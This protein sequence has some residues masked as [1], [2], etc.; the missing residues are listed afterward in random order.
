MAVRTI[1]PSPSRSNTPPTSGH[2]PSRSPSPKFRAL[3]SNGVLPGSSNALLGPYIAVTTARTIYQTKHSGDREIKID[4]GLRIIEVPF[5]VVGG[6]GSSITTAFT[7]GKLLDLFTI[8]AQV[9]TTATKV[10]VIAGFIICG[11]EAIYESIGLKRAIVFLCKIHGI[12]TPRHFFEW[13]LNFKNKTYMKTGLN[14]K[15]DNF[16]QLH[17]DSQAQAIALYTARRVQ[18]SDAHRRLSAEAQAQVGPIPA[19][20]P[21]DYI[22]S[23]SDLDAIEDKINNATL[24]SLLESLDRRYFSL[25][26]KKIEEIGQRVTAEF[27]FHG[28][29]TRMDVLNKAAELLPTEIYRDVINGSNHPINLKIRAQEA[30]RDF[31]IQEKTQGKR[32]NLADRVRI[33]KA[34][35]VVDQLPGI[36]TQLKSQNP[37]I[38]TNGRAAATHLLNDLKTQG[39]KKALAHTISLTAVVFTI[40]GL[41]LTIACPYAALALVGIGMIIGF[42]RYLFNNGVSDTRGWNFEAS[43][44]VPEMVKEFWNWVCKEPTT[45]T[46]AFPLTAYPLPLLI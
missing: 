7:L 1:S 24:L 4:G 44:C 22:Q 42:A 21:D 31:L 5:S 16:A 11:I 46:T 29:F 17:N 20:N 8:S 33:W 37:A 13:L 28:A 36:L 38:Q 14:T 39:Q 30:Y 26:E 12:K 18:L 15:I 32:N 41:A 40:V 43:N 3:D 35:E 19:E 27:S 23:N 25:S 9:V 2:T 45:R 6:A 10:S 34:Q